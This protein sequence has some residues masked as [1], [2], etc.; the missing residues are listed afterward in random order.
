MKKKTRTRIGS[1][2]RKTRDVYNDRWTRLA[3]LVPVVLMTI[4]FGAVFTP[5]HHSLAK[6]PVALSSARLDTLFETAARL[7]TGERLAFWSEQ[8][9]KD[10]TLLA[11]LGRGPTID[12]T[13]PVFPRTYDCTTFVETVAA[14]ARSEGGRELADNVIAIRYRG[15]KVSYET[16]NHFPEADWIPNNERSG[17]LHDITTRVARKTGFLVSFA[18]KDIDKLAWFKAQG[19]PS[20]VLASSG[21]VTE[22]ITARVPYVP[23]EH[24]GSA[25]KNVPE[26]AVV[27]VVRQSDD[28]HPVLI[29][30]QG[31]IVWKGDV[32]F[33]RHAARNKGIAEVPFARYVESMRN[34][35][36]RVVGFNFNAFN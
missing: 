34:Q 15:G 7:K 24:L 26:G 3:W 6:Y 9:Y 17:V 25:V 18:S 5:T 12:D 14:L 11:P 22:P 21:G 1:R 29:S 20:R 28:A 2:P 36:W 23:F 35:P 8:L 4:A 13:A 10:P 33:L 32:A 16:R 30:H 31:F 27:N 19:A